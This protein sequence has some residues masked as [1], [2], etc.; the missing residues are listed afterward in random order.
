MSAGDTAA[1]PPF[2]TAVQDPRLRDAARESG[3]SALAL[4]GG[5]SDSRAKCAH[6]QA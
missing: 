4:L 1:F 3:D 5:L 2:L 6:A